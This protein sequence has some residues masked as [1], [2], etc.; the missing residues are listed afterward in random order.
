ML[1]VENVSFRHSKEGQD[2]IH[3]I[4]FSAGEGEITTVLGPNGSGKT[5]LFRC[6]VGLWRPQHGRVRFGER[7]L[8]LLSAHDRARLIAVVPQDH[9]PPF[10]YT[11]SDIVIMG[12]ASHVAMFSGPTDRDV[13]AAHHA[14]AS[15]GIEHLSGRPYTKISGGERQLVLIARA[16]AQQAPV[17]ILDEPTSHLDFRNQVLVLE[18]VRSIVLERGLT[19]L[20]TLHD[21]NM[22]LLFSDQALVLG[23]G[24][25]M[26]KGKPKEVIT[27]ETLRMVYG[28]EVSVVNY[29]GTAFISP[30]VS[31]RSTGRTT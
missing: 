23:A 29:N 7:E 26:A 10:P 25:I 17:L 15:V 30:K 4:S 13:A 2:I 5:T 14:I 16:L 11:V 28:I 8:M 21:P 3:D 9:E 6:L 22:A 18:T 27:A 12:R 19:A 31:P 1:Q 24:R 20:M